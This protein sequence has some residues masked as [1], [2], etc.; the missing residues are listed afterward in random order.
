MTA[1]TDFLFSQ[2][3]GYTPLLVV[4]EVTAILFGLLSVIFSARNNI[5][6]YPAG[7]VSTGLYIY[8]MYRADLYGDLII[9]GYYFYMSIY[10]WL[11]WSRRDRQDNSRLKITTVTIKDNIKSGVIFT[12]SVIFVSGVYIFFDMFSFW[13]AYVDTFITGLFFIGMWLLAKRKIENW[14]YLIAGD[15]IAIPLFFYKGLIFTGFYY[16]VLTSIAFYGYNV[17]KRILRSEKQIHSA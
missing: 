16:I 4:I 12:V 2:F 6:V 17:W 13:W 3:S 15:I 1:F 7:L 11:L 5:L 14:A 9:N 10:G 8:L